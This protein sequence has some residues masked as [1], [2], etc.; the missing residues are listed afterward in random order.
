MPQREFGCRFKVDTRDAKYS[1]RRTT[2]DATAKYWYDN[3]IFGDQKSSPRCVGY[4]WMHLMVNEPLQ[5]WIS[6]WGLYEIAQKYDEWK[7][8]NYAGTSVRAGAKVLKKLGIIAEYN[9][10]PDIDAVVNTLLTKGPIVVGTLWYAGMDNPVNGAVK[11][12]G[13]RRG[14]HAY[15]LNGVNIE[16][17]MIRI[18]NSWGRGWGIDGRAR[19]SFDDMSTLLNQGGNACIAVERQVTLPEEPKKKRKK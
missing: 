19:I 10:C 15:L 12:T 4:A 9:W 2:T 16:K 3:R 5:Q 1:V 8:T 6:G 14:G 13:R 11:P 7:G 18:K 17:G